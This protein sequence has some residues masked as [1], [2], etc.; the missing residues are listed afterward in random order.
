MRGIG[1]NFKT[2][3]TFRLKKKRNL[4]K[5]FFATKRWLWH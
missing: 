5:Q 1:Q 3:L 4:A 2:L